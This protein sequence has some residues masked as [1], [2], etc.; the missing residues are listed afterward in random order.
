MSYPPTQLVLRSAAR[1]RRTTFPFLLLPAEL[2]ALIYDYVLYD[3]YGSVDRYMEWYMGDID[4]GIL[5]K[6]DY[7]PVPALVTPSILL[8]NRQIYWESLHT[9]RRQP[10]V[11]KHGALGFPMSSLISEQT[12]RNIQ[13]IIMTDSGHNPLTKR[14]PKSFEGFR[15]LTKFLAHALRLPD[16]R[17]KKLE[18]RLTNKECGWHV[19]HCWDMPPA[20][21]GCDM[22]KW[23]EAM[24]LLWK[25]VREINTVVI[26]G[27]FPKDLATDL[28]RLMQ[29]PYNP[30]A[31]L[32]TEVRQKI[33]FLAAD[34]NDAGTQ[35]LKYQKYQTNTPPALSTP[36]MLLLERRTTWEFQQFMLR[37]TPLVIDCPDNPR[38]EHMSPFDYIG[39]QT[40]QQVKH[41]RLAL[42]HWTWCYM[43]ARVAEVLHAAHSLESFHLHFE[44]ARLLD[45]WPEGVYVPTQELAAFFLPLIQLRGIREVRVTGVLPRCFAQPL[46]RSMMTP[47][48]ED[49]VA[50]G[51]FKSGG[52]V[53]VLAPGGVEKVVW[54]R[55]RSYLPSPIRYTE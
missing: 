8:L 9:L 36:N 33:Y 3:A 17:L 46:E 52:H 10:L 34:W 27:W 44:D 11:L 18:L 1:K 4:A 25:N 39:P 45:P 49:R 41:F 38:P 5:A 47:R 6:F 7:P 53:R 24:Y 13:H 23:I 54:K 55:R 16:H 12:V 26:D 31:R 43:I 15:D 22:R 42:R 32:P 37:D 48:G 50:I 30:L 51:Q 20:P 19:T 35:L 14:Y 2:R 29:S 21:R 28:T 40:L